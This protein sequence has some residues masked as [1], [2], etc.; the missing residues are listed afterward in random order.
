MRVKCGQH[1][2][3][4]YHV[5]VVYARQKRCVPTKEV[6]HTMVLSLEQAIKRRVRIQ[7]V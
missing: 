1:S 7:K 2:L 3:V 4:R 6:D 5:A